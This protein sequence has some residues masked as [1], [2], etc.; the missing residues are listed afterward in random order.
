MIYQYYIY[1]TFSLKIINRYFAFTEFYNEMVS[2]KNTIHCTS[3]IRKLFLYSVSIDYFLI[4]KN[5]IGEIRLFFNTSDLKFMSFVPLLIAF[6]L[7]LHRIWEPT[8]ACDT[9]LR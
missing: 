3:K 2:N 6:A 4:L 7:V 5:H 8:H 1:F 9:I